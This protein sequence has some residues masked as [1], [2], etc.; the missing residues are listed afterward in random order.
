MIGSGRPKSQKMAAT[1]SSR[2]MMKTANQRM[3]SIAE[4]ILR[5]PLRCGPLGGTLESE[6]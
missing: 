4:P 3:T 6:A 1:M 2:A 5:P